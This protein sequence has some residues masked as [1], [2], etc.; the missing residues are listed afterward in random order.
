L[1]PV[2]CGHEFHA[3]CYEK[4]LHAAGV[5]P[6]DLK[7]PVCRVTP[8]DLRTMEER[9]LNSGV[10]DSSGGRAGP[11]SA[12]P[13]E[14]LIRIDESQEHVNEAAVED[15]E[16]DAETL[17]WGRA[18]SPDH[19]LGGAATPVGGA[20]DGGAAVPAE[21]E[22]AA[23]A[24]KAK[25]ARGRAKSTSGADAAV[26]PKAKGR[27]KAAAESKA[28]AA[29]A[30]SKAK[31]AAKAGKAP[32]EVKAKAKSVESK[33]AA[34]AKGK[35]KATAV[36]SEVSGKAPAEGKAK[37]KAIESKAKVAAAGKAKPTAT[38]EPAGDER[39]AAM[40]KAVATPK[41]SA[42]AC[43]KP[44]AKGKAKSAAASSSSVPAV[45]EAD[46]VVAQVLA[47]AAA[48]EVEESAETAAEGDPDVVA[49][50]M[51]GSQLVMCDCCGRHEHFNSCRLISKMKQTWRCAS[52]GVKTTQ[53]RR[54]F[55]SWPTD[56][57][58]RLSKDRGADEV[59]VSG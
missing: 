48:S 10:A 7:C 17:S 47:V 20:D 58:C 15:G 22:P 2:E 53:L 55:G 44:A 12:V 38:V 39:G 16:T 46:D 18:D 35:A 13:G 45:E 31:A 3:E 59:F 49:K 36:E 14:P 50:G 52:C 37:A 51:F 29:A 54:A 43:P 4:V 41:V 8:N 34:A 9:L 11:A 5:H 27:S 25:S 21:E 30:P 40:A 23:P 26:P 42:L 24:A 6:H 56:N 1:Y 57:F 19:E 33:A 28:K 32:A